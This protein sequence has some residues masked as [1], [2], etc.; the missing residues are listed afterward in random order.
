MDWGFV[1][2]LDIIII[3]GGIICIIIGFKKGFLSKMLSIVGIIAIIIF[4]IFFASSFAGFL[5]SHDIIYPGIYNN[6][7]GNIVEKL[8]DKSDYTIKEAI[9]ASGFPEFLAGWIS[10][11]IG[12]VDTSEIIVRVSEQ[13]AG[14]ILNV[15]A[16]GILVVACLVGLLIFKI[17]IKC[18]RQVM[19]VK[20]L[21]GIL[22][23]LLY[24]AIYLVILTGLF[25]LLNI[26]YNQE[27]FSQ[28]KG[29]LDTDM[30]IGKESFRIS[31]ALFERNFFVVVISMF[32]FW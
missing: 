30:A 21:D 17:I 15:I 31:K 19:L 6:I 9:Q 23:A 27:W 28:A 25:A 20:V 5:K 10:N 32:K 16:F 29:W 22:G 4:A 13:I 14:W 12:E 11:A 2:L 24:F 7:H 26:F 3:L 1:G 18:I 8:G